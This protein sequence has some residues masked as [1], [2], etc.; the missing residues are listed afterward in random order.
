[1]IG[2]LP[3]SQSLDMRGYGLIEMLIATAIGCVLLG[4]LLQFAVSAHT[5]AGVQSEVAD[6]QQRLRVALESMRH[7]LMFAGAGPSRG[8]DRG[9][10]ARVCPPIIPART[11][12]SGAD[13]ELSFHSD[14]ISIV[15]VP[16]DAA[17]SKL[18]A[19]MPTAA[20]PI[21][22]DG[23]APGC[24]PA[25]GCDFLTGADT[26]IYEPAG[27]GGA[28]EVFSVSA[29]DVATNTLTPAAAL[30]R[31]YSARARVAAVVHRTYYLDGSGKR[32]MVYDGAR[33]D[34]PLVDHVVGLNFAYY[35][36]PNPAAIAAPAPGESNCAYAGSPPVSLL[37]DLG[38][39]AP[40]AL[41]AGLLTD[42]PVCGE[43]P[44]LFDADLLRIRRVSVTI[45]VEAESAEFRGRGSA[46]ATFGVSRG[47]GRIVSDLKTT[48][49]VTPRNMIR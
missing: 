23:A 40:K 6:I 4:V 41:T 32:L 13:S 12:L 43:S 16:D 28:H 21:A 14:R 33:S 39:A 15:Y 19:D 24:R 22:I 20:S 10:L 26:L 42:G 1:M 35:V 45:R 36:D 46:F 30:S 25:S 31:A 47:G 5:S 17:Q 38:G 29:V 11:G 7:D 9:P 18:A 2:C 48:I 44:H 27:V 3:E 8:P 37:T 49:D 34:V